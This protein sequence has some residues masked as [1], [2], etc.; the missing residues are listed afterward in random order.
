[1]PI[2]A[3]YAVVQPMLDSGLLRRIFYRWSSYLFYLVLLWFALAAAAAAIRLLGMS[4]RQRAFAVPLLII[5][6]GIPLSQVYRNQ[7][8]WMIPYDDNA[9]A[10]RQQQRASPDSED[11]FYLQPKLLERELAALKPGRKG[12]INLYLIGAAGVSD[13][14]VFMKEVRYV[15]DMFKKRFGTEGR[16]V[17]LINNPKT[18][19]LSPIASTTSLGL[20]L[21]RVGEVMNRDKDILFL[22][23]TSHGSKDH[24]FTLSFG[25]MQFNDLDPKRLR[26]M[27][28]ESGIKRRVIVVS[29]CYSGG[30]VDAL[31]NENSLVITA[32]A[33]DRNSFGCSNEAE[34]TY[35]GK[36]YF[37]EALRK[38]DSFIDAFDLAKP[39]IAAR[40]KKDDF[41]SSNPRIFVGANIR[42][43]LAEFAGQW[44]SPAKQ[45]RGDKPD[46][47]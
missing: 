31:K 14:D 41:L 15:S 29:A 16:S 34:F 19:A 1:L 6:I 36:A 18:A 46:R 39:I 2:E 11:I 47:R 23:L 33:A 3:F 27:L 32:S 22:Y 8:L 25:S 30:F 40:E 44:K 10:D 9:I 17:M 5:A 4:M 20:A 26:A 24:K 12:V 38:T 13:Q 45:E 28:D 35:F 7:T 42:Q 21:K 37:D 43:P